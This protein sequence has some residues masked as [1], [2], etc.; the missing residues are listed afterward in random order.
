MNRVRPITPMRRGGRNNERW[1]SNS[2]IP[3][4]SSWARRRICVALPDC[5]PE[6]EILRRAQDDRVAL[7]VLVVNVHHRV[8]TI[9]DP[10]WHAEVPRW[11]RW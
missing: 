6:P 5:T 8:S 10:V 11:T 9:S 4:L 3:C 1:P 2:V 7:P